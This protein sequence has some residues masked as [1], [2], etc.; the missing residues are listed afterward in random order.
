MEL[1]SSEMITIQHQYDTL[2]KKPLKA[3][4]EVITGSFPNAPPMK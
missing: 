4:Q 2:A 1:S 3:K